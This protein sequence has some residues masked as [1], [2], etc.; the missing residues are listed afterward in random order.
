MKICKAVSAM[1][2]HWSRQR[3]VPNRTKPVTVN[4]LHFCCGPGKP[5]LASIF[6]ILFSGKSNFRFVSIAV[7]IKRL[8]Q[9]NENF[10][11]RKKLN[12][13]TADIGELTLSTRC[14]HCVAS[15]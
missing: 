7:L 14:R 5:P 12:Y 15:A 4:E 6:D 3:V 13:P 11:L 1:H 9:S 10:R 8:L 2:P